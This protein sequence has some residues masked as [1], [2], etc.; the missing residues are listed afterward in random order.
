NYA[1]K[2]VSLIPP[3]SDEIRDATLYPPRTECEPS[4][5]FV[6]PRPR[7]FKTRTGPATNVVKCDQKI[8][9]VYK[10]D[11]PWYTKLGW[12]RFCHWVGGAG[13]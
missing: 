8:L 10:Q 3:T 13:F 11:G 6:D 2:Y 9:Y 12:Y 5:M 4:P 7:G 1:D